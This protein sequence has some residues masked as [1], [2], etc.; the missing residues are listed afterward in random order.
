MS[1]RIR[2][3]ANPLALHHLE[4]GAQRLDLPPALPVEVALGCADAQFLFERA[5]RDPRRTYV[6]I[7]IRKDLVERVNRAT[8]HGRRIPVRAVYANAALDLETLF[9]RRSVA[10]CHV[11]FPDPCFKGRQKKRRFVTPAMVRSLA[12][13]LAPG[14]RVAFQS[15]VFDIALASLAVFEEADCWFENE[16]GPWSFARENPFGAQSRREAWCEARGVRIWRFRFQRRRARSGLGAA[17]PGGQSEPAG[18]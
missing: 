10:L 15:D 2:Q 14:G 12:Q 9:A 4:T 5:H 16:L 13:I 6:G 17:P 1:R 11:N 8:D 18:C 3:H 7:E